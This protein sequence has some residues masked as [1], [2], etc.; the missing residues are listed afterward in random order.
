MVEN[1]KREVSSV[2]KSFVNLLISSKYS[3]D[4]EELREKTLSTKSWASSILGVSLK[5]QPFWNNKHV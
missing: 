4:N 1:N 2:E 5:I 3:L